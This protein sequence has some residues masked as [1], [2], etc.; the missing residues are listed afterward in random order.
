MCTFSDWTFNRTWAF[1]KKINNKKQNKKSNI[2]KKR[3][4]QVNFSQILQNSFKNSFK[5][6]L[7][8]L[9]FFW[10]KLGPSLIERLNG[11][12]HLFGP[13]CLCRIE[14]DYGDRFSLLWY[15]TLHS[16]VVWTEENAGKSEFTIF[17]T[18]LINFT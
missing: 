16:E 13:E 14:I 3:I 12:K 15:K 2:Y 9:F 17:A 18:W 7:Q 4:R 8:N 1:L 5:N 10:F 6:W 11:P